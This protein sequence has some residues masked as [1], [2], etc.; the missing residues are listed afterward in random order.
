MFLLPPLMPHGKILGF[1]SE[2]HELYLLPTEDGIDQISCQVW[3]TL[4]AEHGISSLVHVCIQR[5]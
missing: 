3:G 5:L 1:E 2:H 4:K